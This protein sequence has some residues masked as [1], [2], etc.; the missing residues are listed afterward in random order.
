VSERDQYP[1][2]VPCWVDTLHRDPRRA[3]DFYG[4]LF[5]WEFAGPGPM[6]ADPPGEYFVARVR[7]RDVAGIGSRPDPSDQS[8][9]TWTTYVRVESA[10]G[11]LELAREAGGTVIVDPVDAPPA[12]RLAVIADP[13]GAVIG[14]WEGASREGAQIVNEPSAWSM[15]MLHTTDAPVATEFYRAVFGWEAEPFGAPAAR[16]ALFRLPGYTG[17]EPQQP[18]PRDVVAVMAAGAGESGEPPPHWGVD[19][20]VKDADAAAEHAAELGGAVIVQPH[21]QP[22]FRSAVIADPEGARFSINELVRR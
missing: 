20:W 15:S 9:A 12:G 22:G 5:G 18:V 4:P 10:D 16:L 6:P 8:P 14:V 11:A 17:G 3:M 13:T 19:L 7:G 1:A 21:D 2:G